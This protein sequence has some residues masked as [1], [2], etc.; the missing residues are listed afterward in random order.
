MCKLVQLLGSMLVSLLLD[1]Q[2][3]LYCNKGYDTWVAR[4]VCGAL[5]GSWPFCRVVH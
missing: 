1:L 5:S 3:C 2:V 4:F